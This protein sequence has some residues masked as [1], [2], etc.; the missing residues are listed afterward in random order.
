[1]SKFFCKM[2]CADFVSRSFWTI[3][4]YW[5]LKKGMFPGILLDKSLITIYPII[6]G[7][8]VI[9]VSWYSVILVSWNPGIRV[10]WY[11]GILLY[12][13]PDI[14]VSC[15]PGVLVSW[16]SG[17][18]VSW[19]LGILVSWYPGIL[20]FFYPVILLSWY[21]DI[22]CMYPGILAFNHNGWFHKEYNKRW[23]WVHT[24]TEGW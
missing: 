19:Y 5:F 6:Q 20:E 22:L 8:P 4:F 13:Y 10:S 24:E 23:L 12:W 3:F 11:S 9:L 16:Y 17:I 21:P 7:Y 2:F 1:M 14:L 15:Y 18:L